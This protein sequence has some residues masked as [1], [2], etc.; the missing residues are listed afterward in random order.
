MSITVHDNSALIVTFTGQILTDFR[1]HDT[2]DALDANQRPGKPEFL[3][4]VSMTIIT[5]SAAKRI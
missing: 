4:F 1:K 3:L 2:D 5:S